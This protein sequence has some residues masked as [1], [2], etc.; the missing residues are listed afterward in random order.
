[1]F[2]LPLGEPGDDPEQVDPER[3]DAEQEPQ[4]PAAEQSDGAPSRDL[5]PGAMRAIARASR[6]FPREINVLCDNALINGFGYKAKPVSRKI[7]RMVAHEFAARRP[8][9]AL[10]WLTA[11]FAASL[12]FG[13]TGTL[14]Y[15]NTVRSAKTTQAQSARAADTELPGQQMPTAI[16]AGQ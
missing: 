10:K 16:G 4:Q 2:D 8:H 12:V 13:L 7:A 11:A 14:M 9:R 3:D 6:G 15:A 5:A 1:M